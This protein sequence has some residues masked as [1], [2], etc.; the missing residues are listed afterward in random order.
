MKQPKLEVRAKQ[1]IEVDGLKF[2]DLNGNGKL[3]PYEDWRLPYA[4]RVKDLV[5]QMNLDEK[6]GMMLINTRFTGYQVPAGE[7]TSHDGI[8]DERV[9]EEGTNI[10]AKR[11]IWPTTHT[12]NELHLRHFILRDNYSPTKLARWNNAMNEICEASR[13]G[14]P[15][16]STSNPR[17]ENAEFVFGMNDAMGVFSTF[18]ATMGI[19]AAV[20]GEKA[21][22]KDGQIFSDFAQAARIEWNA[23]GIRKGYMYMADVV[24]DPRWQRTYGTFGEDPE[25][26]ADAMERFVDGFQGDELSAESISLT[27]K[28]F[29]GGG[30]RENGFDPH[31]KEGKWNCYLTP[32]SLEKY[33]LPGFLAALKSGSFMPYYSAPSISK[34]V[35]QKIAGQD[36]PFEEVGFAFN[37]YLLEEVLRRR[38]GFKGYVNSDSGITDNMCW[39]VEE[40]SIPERFAKAINAGTDIVADTNN[41]PDLKTAIEKG[42]ISMERVDEANSRLLLEMF[43]LGLFD[44]RTYVDAEAADEIVANSPGWE[45]AKEV[46]RKSVVLMK[47]SNQTL[48]LAEGTKVY[49]QM[50]HKKPETSAAKTAEAREQIGAVP[51]LVIVDQPEDAD[52][53]FLMV[54]PQSGDYFNA[55]P[56][57]LELTIC[58]NKPLKAVDGTEYTETT[59]SGAEEFRQMA[60]DGRAR[61][62]KVIISINYS[63]AWIIDDIEPLADALI[64][65]FHSF[66]DAQGEVIAGK[67]KPQGKLPITPP[68]SE[69]VI[70]VD[71]QGVC[72]SPNDVPGYDKDQYLPVGMSYAYTDADGNVYRLGHGLTY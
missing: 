41:A 39:G 38:F 21:L 16:I 67:F 5:S 28:H 17:N 14:I 59:V 23:A 37:W 56:G 54:D 26:I 30:P 19:A 27:T 4:E 55:T 47:N 71:E 65:S 49:V 44:E 51:G 15:C 2:K 34:S 69:A 35:V 68:A 29:P 32:G 1:L 24:T 7:P 33:H 72:I 66:F 50:W 42:W 57:L 43:Q 64:G 3:D 10:F 48:P 58:E 62:Q 22:G 45:K 13:L 53:L 11:K 20:L 61:G 9:I 40:L 25:L 18:P 8:I 70:A 6:V 36:V 63:L 31:Y 46:H 12:I 52:A 60:R